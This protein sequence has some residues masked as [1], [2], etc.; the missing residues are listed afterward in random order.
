MFIFSVFRHSW[1]QLTALF[2]QRPLEIL[3]LTAFSVPCLFF[4]YGVEDYFGLWLLFP[5][6][7]AVVYL[8]R[9][10]TWCYWLS[11]LLLS[12][13]VLWLYRQF[14]FDFYFYEQSPQYWGAL[15][16]ALICF[17]SA[18]WFKDNRQ[19]VSAV[20]GKAV[21]L[22][23]FAPFAA[24]L[25]FLLL[26]AILWSIDYLFN[27]NLPFGE[28]WRRGFMFTTFGLM[29]LFFLL[30]ERHQ[31]RQQN[32]FIELVIHFILS[33]ALILYSLLLYAYLTTI[34][35]AGELPRGNVSWIVLPYLFAAIVLSA[36][37]TLLS[38]A[39]WLRFYRWLPYILLAP[40]GLLWLGI[41]E[42]ISTY[43]FTVIRIYLVAVAV[44]VT[45]F[46]LLGLWQRALQYRNLAFIA[47]LSVFLT[48]YV[49]NPQGIEFASQHTRLKQGMATLNI[50][51]AEGK[52]KPH[53]E[54]INLYK[55]ATEAEKAQFHSLSEL[56]ARLYR[57]DK[58][59]AVQYNESAFADLQHSS[60]RTT[61]EYNAEIHRYFYA[62]ERILELTGYKRVLTF[63]SGRYITP[64]PIVNV[65]DG[66]VRASGQISEDLAVS[67]D[68]DEHIR[69]ILQNNGFALDREYS[70][71]ELEALT[72]QFTL[73][74][75]AEGVLIFNRFSMRFEETQGYIFNEAEVSMF[76]Q[77]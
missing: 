47:V 74:E 43:A 8:S 34:V 62:N 53:N 56:A 37:Q 18:G 32:Y 59:I 50:L 30:F 10:Q 12:A 9:R 16:I 21:N 24:Y 48:T 19:Y 60:Y 38:K 11:P 35:F 65:T 33:P 71:E 5:I 63:P 28:I 14:G 13:V 55:Q 7:F 25:C 6:L 41:I 69:N 1:R 39:R 73:A 61:M 20:A 36:A 77:K 49:I 23:L 70:S 52:I 57:L 58:G 15:L 40:L 45:I 64:T 44:T 26:M 75:T 31:I 72:D 2:A 27:A 22:F 68:G 3:L 29:P 67:F 51:D 17:L 46:C 76:L 42:R 66:S 54:L 4:Q